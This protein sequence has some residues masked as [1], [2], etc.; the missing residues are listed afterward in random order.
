MPQMRTRT[1]GVILAGTRPPRRTPHRRTTQRKR[2]PTHTTQQVLD[3]IRREG[4]AARKDTSDDR[5]TPKWVF[6]WLELNFDIDV[7]APIEGPLHTPCAH[8][9]HQENSGLDQPWKGLVFMNPPYSKPTPWVDKFLE[10]GNGVALMPT[11]IG[12]W[13]LRVWHHPDT[14]M[15]PMPPTR[16]EGPKL[17]KTYAPFRCWLI[18]M[19][20]AAH[21]AIDRFEHKV[22]QSL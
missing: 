17:D 2:L 4:W 20:L 1:I 12:K 18:G 11:S 7:A 10:H 9:F 16:F 13:F 15:T 22:S 3:M 5:F 14:R 21:E 19:G 8:W 6:D